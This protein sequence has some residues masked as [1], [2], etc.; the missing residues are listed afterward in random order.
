VRRFRADFERH[1][2]ERRCPF[3]DSFEI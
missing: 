2:H 1:V 3:P